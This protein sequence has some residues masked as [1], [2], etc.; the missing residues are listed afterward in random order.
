MYN[1]D[2]S[3]GFPLGLNLDTISLLVNIGIPIVYFANF[4]FMTI[5]LKGMDKDAPFYAFIKSLVYFFFFYGLGAL[6]FF[7]FDFFYMDGY[8]PNPIDV[9]F[10]AEAAPPDQA[11]Y[12]WQIGNLIQNVGLFLMVMQLR[13]RVFTGK[14]K[15]TL[16]VVWE[17]FGLGIMIFTL[18]NFF[19]GIGI[20]IPIFSD[21][22]LFW[23][24]MNF[25]FNFTWSISLPL[26]YSY[27][28]KNAAGKMKK[29]AFILFLCFILYGIAWGLRSKTAVYM[30][31]LIF[32]W[33]PLL[34]VPNPFTY[35]LIWIIRGIAITF[36]LALVLYAY[37]KL[38]GEF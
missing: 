22:P 6:Y 33:L 34:G 4:I 18:V 9:L 20:Y 38:L 37:N 30:A 32:E 19:A 28:W 13:K 23:T 10:G 1:I 3:V 36:N 2:F 29:Y 11:A 31:I 27:I 15:Q 16:P 5:K 8:I 35:Q 21:T 12:L 24:E 7:W 14:F 26:T 25:L 17:I